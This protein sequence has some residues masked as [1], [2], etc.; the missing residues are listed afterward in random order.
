MGYIT[1]SK[2][3]LMYDHFMPNVIVD[4]E[5]ISSHLQINRNIQLSSLIANIMIK[6]L[7]IAL[8]MKYCHIYVNTQPLKITD[9][10]CKLIKDKKIYRKLKESYELT[11]SC[12]VAIVDDTGNQHTA[13]KYDTGNVNMKFILMYEHFMP[14]IIDNKE[15]V[16]CCKINRNIK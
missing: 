14:N 5:T 16:T 3:I 4:K 11:I 2:V 12:E 7:F 8:P 6:N 10:N 15:I 13:K 1:L 9:Y